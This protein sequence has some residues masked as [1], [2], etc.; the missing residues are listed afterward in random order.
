MT[1][2]WRRRLE[3]SEVGV[4]LGSGRL[5]AKSPDRN[6]RL[7]RSAGCWSRS[8]G[9]LWSC[10]S[11][12]T[13]SK[14]APGD[15][16]FRGACGGRGSGSDKAARGGA[17]ARLNTSLTTILSAEETGSTATV[18][19]SLATHGAQGVAELQLRH[20]CPA[21]LDRCWPA[22]SDPGLPTCGRLSLGAS[23][24]EK[25]ETRPD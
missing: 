23:K 3:P 21:R 22:E 12:R 10:S 19:D 8:R 17:S 2:C 5:T 25:H 18:G 1:S 14:A 4:V 13:A 7:A 11:P 6:S 15:A 16:W 20:L 9:P 24:P